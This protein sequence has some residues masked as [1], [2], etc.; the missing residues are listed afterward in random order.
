M[1]REGRIRPDS[2]LRQSGQGGWMPASRVKGLFNDTAE[3]AP[4][5]PPAV[6]QPWSPAPAA[7]IM[8]VSPAPVPP[9]AYPQASPP[10]Y[11]QAPPPPAPVYVAQVAPPPP[12]APRRASRPGGFPLGVVLAG[13]GGV[14][15]IGL[16]TVGVVIFFVSGKGGM[17]ARSRMSTEKIVA[18]SEK[19]VAAIKGKLGGGSGFLV[20]DGIV[21][22]SAHVISLEFV[23]NLTVQF[24]SAEGKHKEARVTS[25]L[26]YDG[27]RD[28]AL[29]R[30]KTT[31][32]PL[33]LA[34]KYEFRRG[35]SL[36]VIGNPGFGAATLDNAVS[37]G[38]M[39]SETKVNGLPYYQMSVAINPG[40]SGGPVLDEYGEVIGVATAKV[41]DRESLAFCIP[42]EDVLKALDEVKSY[43]PRESARADARHRAASTVQL[44][45]A[46]CT[47]Y[48]GAMLRYVNSMESALAARADHNRAWQNVRTEIA[49]KVANLN[50]ILTA[51]VKPA[52]N[53]LGSDAGL[54]DKMRDNLIELWTTYIELQSYFDRP[55][56]NVATYKSKQI[57]LSD[58]YKRLSTALKASL[59]VS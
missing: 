11:M 34:R 6:A 27:R 55:R 43:G 46:V 39:S 41:K 44:L 48:D 28:L 24:P 18:R 33:P 3:L 14:V 9:P 47:L 59:G 17:L 23:E 13:A 16:I 22:T 38:V 25:V 53:R 56:G 40:N 42:I 21:A 19:S 45:E 29:L 2:W 7:P 54:P 30:V 52:I 12:P 8:A 5:P 15:L 1:A 10:A 50:A 58:R 37:Q 26:H 51:D 32:E 20:K 35:Q 57:E 49:P 31:L 4:L 36:V